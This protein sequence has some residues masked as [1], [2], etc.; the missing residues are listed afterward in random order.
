MKVL[1]AVHHFPP[2]FLGGA[3]W[4]AF[5]IAEWLQ[6]HGHDVRV[7]CVE[8]DRAGAPGEITFRDEPYCG[9]PVRRLMFNLCATPMPQQERWKFD[10]PLVANQ[11]DA[12]LDEFEPDLLHLVSGYLLSGS[13]ITTAKARG[14]PV[15]YMPMDLWLVCPRIMFQ[16]TDDT[17]CRQ[18]GDPATCEICLRQQRRRYRYLNLLTRGRFSRWVYRLGERLPLSAWPGR[19]ERTDLLIERAE[20][21]H[22]VFNLVDSVVVNSHFLRNTLDEHGFDG[23]RIYQMRQGLDMR[24]WQ[25]VARGRKSPT[26]HLRIG[27][28]GQIAPHKGIDL[29]IRAFKRLRPGVGTPELIIYGDSTKNPSYAAWLRG[30]AGRHPGIT[31]AGSFDNT[32]VQRVHRDLDLVVVPSTSYENSPNVILESFAAGTPVIGADIGGIPELLRDGGGELFTAND[33]N[34]L[35]EHLQRLVDR[36]ILLQYYQVHMPAHPQRESRNGR[37]VGRL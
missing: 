31:F 28:T 5:R 30:L 4:Q 37:P 2:S 20:Y 34:D 16:R 24:V 22:H 3:E 1:L 25:G 7:I 15:V 14:I 18:A 21:L 27:Y 23:E 11:I 29:L 10:N 26:D 36:P 19:V 35:A 17:P 12:Y 6:S 8:T 9:I 13:A 33:E 32:Q